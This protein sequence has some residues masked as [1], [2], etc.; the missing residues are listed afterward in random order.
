MCACA[1]CRHHRRRRPPDRMVL[2]VG[3][4]MPFRMRTFVVKQYFVQFLYRT[5][6]GREL[7][8]PLC[9]P[10]NSYSQN[11]RLVRVGW[12]KVRSAFFKWIFRNGLG[13]CA[14]CVRMACQEPQRNEV[15]R[16]NLRELD[17]FKLVRVPLGICMWGWILG[18]LLLT[19]EVV[20]G[21]VVLRMMTVQRDD[22]SKME[23]RYSS[24]WKRWPEHW[25]YFWNYFCVSSMRQRIR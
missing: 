3:A 15:C 12:L 20:L 9:V 25:T 11:W 10:T 22:T 2:R 14:G 4:G 18:L 5:T 24:D 16:R 1:R 19:L 21:M 17:F 23:K 7:L 13:L 8:T 6:D